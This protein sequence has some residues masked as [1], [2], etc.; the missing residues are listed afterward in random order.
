[1]SFSF[2]EVSFSFAQRHLICDLVSGLSWMMDNKVA[3][4][5]WL[6]WKMNN[7]YVYIYRPFRLTRAIAR[8]R[9]NLSARAICRT[10]ET[11]YSAEKVLFHRIFFQSFVFVYECHLWTML[12]LWI[13]SIAYRRRS[14][15]WPKRRPKLKVSFIGLFC[16]GFQFRFFFRTAQVYT[17]YYFKC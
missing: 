2:Q 12:N 11:S 8:A 1:M 15:R 10:H 3:T 17:V 14:L 5:K 13:M 6:F 16:V 4:G 7:I 9:A